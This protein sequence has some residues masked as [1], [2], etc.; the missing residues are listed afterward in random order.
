MEA[1]KIYRRFVVE[2]GMGLDQHGQNPT[3]AACKAVKD[4]VANICLAGVIDIARL[5][6]VND[7]KVDMHIACPHPERVDRE[8]VLA[9][10]RA[11]L[12]IVILPER[13]LKDLIDIPK[14]V[15]TDLKIIPVEHMDQVLEVALYPQAVVEPPRPRK[16]PEETQP[17]QVEEE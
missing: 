17:E 9:A 6:D 3:K 7:M 8:K 14:R 11:G 5:S 12:K 15:R 1:Q 16:R 10:H 2:F 13:N 4:A